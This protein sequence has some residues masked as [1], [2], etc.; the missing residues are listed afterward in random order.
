MP[1][2]TLPID[3]EEHNHIVEVISEAYVIKNRVL[4]PASVLVASKKQ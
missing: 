4:R 2:H 1:I 3:G